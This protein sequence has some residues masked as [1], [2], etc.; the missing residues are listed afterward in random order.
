MPRA[1]Q[2]HTKGINHLNAFS[3]DEV[4]QRKGTSLDTSANKTY[5]SMNRTTIGAS[6]WDVE[7]R[8]TG[9]WHHHKMTR[10]RVAHAE[11]SQPLA[12][13]KGIYYKKER[14]I[15]RIIETV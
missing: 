7:W 12:Q 6:N 1:P 11:S 10:A 13:K 14:D 4:A 15:F 5:I 3:A 8:T 2:S 9:T